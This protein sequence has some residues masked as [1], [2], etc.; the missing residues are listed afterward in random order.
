MAITLNPEVKSAALE[1]ARHN[2]EADPT[3][4]AVYLFPAEDEIRLIYLDPVTS[5][6][7]EAPHIHPFYFGRDIPGGM[8]FRSAIAL[9]LPEK[10]FTLLPPEEWGTWNDAELIEFK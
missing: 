7:K 5:P 3:L 10:R 4:Q 6:S 9:I 8:L 1:M 2:L